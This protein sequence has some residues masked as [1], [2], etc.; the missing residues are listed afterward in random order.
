MESAVGII[1][2]GRA[3]VG[4]ALALLR[5]GYTVR[6][7]GRRKRDVPKPLQLTVGLRDAPPP[8]AWLAQ[9][10]VVILAV[11][12]DAIRPPPEGLA[13]GGAIGR[14]HGGLHLSGVQ[15]RGAPAPL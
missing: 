10:G 7:H 4:F 15:G 3:G 12:D 9:A 2:R 6:L 1:G 11:P 13:G 8:P 5:A 14:E